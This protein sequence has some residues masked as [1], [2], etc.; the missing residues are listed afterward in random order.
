[1]ADPTTPHYN[2]TLPTVGLDRDAWGD[3]INNNWTK[4]DA[5]L[6]TATSGGGSLQTQ[7]NAI[8]A[9]LANTIEPVG[10]L[11]PWPTATSPGGWL[12]C[13]G[14]AISRSGFPDL[15]ALIGN[16]YGAGD[17]ATTFNLP[18]YVGRVLVHRDNGTIFVGTLHGESGHV[19][20]ANEM[21]SHSHTGIT[22]LQGVHNHTVDPGLLG[23][24]AAGNMTVTAPPAAT[25]GQTGLID[26]AFI[27]LTPGTKYLG[28][29]VYGG[30]AGLPNPTIVR[31]DP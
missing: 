29:V 18:N 20:T 14:W 30:V 17:G 11:K 3:L 16:T 15:Y 23:S 12:P 25:L 10:S 26:L 7:I 28:S 24:A 22:D 9:A 31:V 1:M 5:D 27:G 8:K 6:W 19:L 4:L 13:D 2:Y 21:P